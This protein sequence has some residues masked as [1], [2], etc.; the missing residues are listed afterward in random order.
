MQNHQDDLIEGDVKE[1][2]QHSG[3]FPNL[4]ANKKK[5]LKYYNYYNYYNY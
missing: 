2:F 4:S 3:A 5:T 1:A